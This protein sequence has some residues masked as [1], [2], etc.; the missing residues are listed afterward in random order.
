MLKQRAAV[1][2]RERMLR[3]AYMLKRNSSGNIKFCDTYSDSCSESAKAVHSPAKSN[4]YPTEF[5]LQSLTEQDEARHSDDPRWI[6]T[7]QTVLWFIFAAMSANVP[8]AEEIVK[9][10]MY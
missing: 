4:T 1:R 2:R 3:S 5:M 7:P 8:I 10:D 6:N 9:P